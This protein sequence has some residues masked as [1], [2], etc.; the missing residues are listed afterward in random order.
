MVIMSL[1]TYEQDSLWHCVP[2]QAI[3]FQPQNSCELYPCPQTDDPEIE[4]RIKGQKH[5]ISKALQKPASLARTRRG[6]NQWCPWKSLSK[7]WSL[8]E[9]PCVRICFLEKVILDQQQSLTPHLR[10]FFSVKKLYFPPF[11]LLYTLSGAQYLKQVRN[12]IS[13]N[14]S[15]FSSPIVSSYTP[16]SP[17]VEVMEAIRKYLET[18]S[19][20]ESQENVSVFEWEKHLWHW[21]PI[22]DSKTFSFQ[23]PPGVIVHIPSKF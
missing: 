13:L 12:K 5:S 15:N 18:S 9:E 19:S 6:P 1:P 22:F 4:I 21:R 3:A 16:A 11:S 2:V 17:A 8:L 10:F 7:T 20:H 23:I 14:S